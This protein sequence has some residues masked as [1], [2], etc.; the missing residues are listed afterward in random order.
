MNEESDFQT[1]QKS[2]KQSLKMK[3]RSDQI[4]ADSFLS[5]KQSSEDVDL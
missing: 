1:S 4:L 5:N 3:K 2:Q